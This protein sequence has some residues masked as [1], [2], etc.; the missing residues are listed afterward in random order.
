MIIAAYL[1]I[2]VI[3]LYM[4]FVLLSNWRFKN[5]VK[6]LFS[7]GN[8]S[9]AKVF[10]FS[11][12]LG[13]PSPVEKYFRLVLKEGQPYPG[14]IRLKH[15]GQ[16]KTALDKPWMP[17]R[18]EQYFTTV[19]AG[20][21]W[22]GDTSLFS[23]RDMFIGAKGR[24]EVFLLDALRVVN[25]RG[26]KF[27]QGELLRWLSESVWFP[28]SLLPDE[29][30]RWIAI[31]QTS[32]RLKVEVNGLVLNY[33]VCFNGKG[34]IASLATKRYMAQT[35]ETWIINLSGYRE[36]NNIIIPTLA[37]AGWKLKGIQYPYARFE[38]KQIEYNK[39][40]RF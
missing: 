24:L 40:F 14:T 33:L 31:D 18:G 9:D 37:E 22:K 5:Q 27:D 2:A 30:K 21:I 3:A 38:V 29:N 11:Q 32:A 10:N 36:I 23:A 25:G 20:F 1:V 26:E 28:T 7:L 8:K 35:L 15:G 13:L 39:P 4:L 17:I 19:P 6:R 12:L 34:E 16:F